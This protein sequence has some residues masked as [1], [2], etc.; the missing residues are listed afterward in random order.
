MVD[1][2][3]RLPLEQHKN[4]YF[5]YDSENYDDGFLSKLLHDS[6]K[7]IDSITDM[8]TTFTIKVKY[9]GKN[10]K[11]EVPCSYESFCATLEQECGTFN[12]IHNFDIQNEDEYEIS[13]Q[14]TLDSYLKDMTTSTAIYL[15][16]ESVN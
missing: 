15:P 10:K 1:Q 3:A 2:V 9:D 7:L 8:T 16:N 14:L 13:S 11:F 5:F 4:E 6:K 12:R